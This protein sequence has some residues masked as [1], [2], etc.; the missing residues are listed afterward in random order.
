MCYFWVVDVFLVEFVDFVG[1][2][3]DYGWQFVL[4]DGELGVCLM[5]YVV[6][7][8]LCEQQLIVC[9]VVVVY[10]VVGQWKME[11]VVE[12]DCVLGVDCG[13]DDE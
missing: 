13:F 6:L 7:V 5:Q 12:Y 8:W 2:C 9:V 11:D 3:D 1:E 4:V 10:L